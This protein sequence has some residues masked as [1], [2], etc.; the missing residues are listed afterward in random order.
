[1]IGHHIDRPFIN[2]LLKSK[3]KRVI[4]FNPGPVMT[5][6]TVKSALIQ[7]DVC[8]RDVDFEIIMQELTSN[9]IRVFDADEE[10][11]VVFISG[12]GTSGLEAA[13]SSAIPEDKK[14]LI[15]NN[16]AFGTRLCEIADLHHIKTVVIKKEWGEL[17]DLAEVEE[18]LRNDPDIFALA[19]NHHET[20]VGVLNPVHELGLLT[21][22]YGKLLIVDA[23]SSLG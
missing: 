11:S 9:A 12:S 16:G 17:F 4:L 15:L 7:N 20:S 10:Y 6:A 22:K 5:T 18:A 14:I 19:V 13:I 8:H 2:L 21:K 3:N 23:V 1:M